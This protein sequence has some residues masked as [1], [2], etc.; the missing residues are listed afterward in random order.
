MSSER[1]LLLATVWAA[2][3]PTV[4]YLVSL[5]GSMGAFAGLYPAAG[6]PGRALLSG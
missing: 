3:P 5:L 4:L 1:P 6:V 2:I